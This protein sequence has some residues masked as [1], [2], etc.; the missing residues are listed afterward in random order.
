MNLFNRIPDL[1]IFDEVDLDCHPFPC[2]L[3]EQQE[4]QED[5]YYCG[6]CGRLIPIEEYHTHTH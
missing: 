1:L 3:D 4:D 5:C 6:T 2:K